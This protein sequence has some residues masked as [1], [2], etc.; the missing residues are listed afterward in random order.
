MFKFICFGDIIK[1]FVL[2][3]LYLLFLADKC[4]FHAGF[5]SVSVWTYFLI[6]SI[7]KDCLLFCSASGWYNPF[8]CKH[9]KVFVMI[10]W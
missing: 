1:K 10:H 4:A 6:Q 2:N 5:S 7:L 9:L 8:I 3:C